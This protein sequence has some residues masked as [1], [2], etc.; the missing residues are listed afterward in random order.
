MRGVGRNV[1]FLGLTSLL[2][3]L[4]SEMVTAVLPIY[5][6]Y[7]LR[8]SP[9]AFGIVDGLQQGGASLVKLASGLLTDRTGRYKTVAGSG[10]GASALSRLGLLAAGPTASWLTPLIALDR[11]GKG[12]RTA[13]R[14]GPFPL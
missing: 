6:L 3:D 10:Y 13:P 1:W 7:F 14:T 4:S 2:T 5:A 9:S 12:I 11:I 8:M